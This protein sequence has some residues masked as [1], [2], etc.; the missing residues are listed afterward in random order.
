MPDN[1]KYKGSFRNVPAGYAYYVVLRLKFQNSYVDLTEGTQ[2]VKLYL[3]NNET[4]AITDKVLEVVGTFPVSGYS[5]DGYV[6]LKFVGSGTTSLSGDYY[7]K[8]IWNNGSEN[9]LISKSDDII[10]IV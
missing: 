5:G 9:I 7:Y 1:V 2:T 8:L 10:K 4:D 6:Q 3:L